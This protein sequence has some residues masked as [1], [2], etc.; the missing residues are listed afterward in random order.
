MKRGFTLLELLVVVGIISILAAL[1]TVSFA[2]VQTRSRDSRRREDMKSVQDSLE[3]YYA[4]NSFVYPSDS[5]TCKA[6]ISSY[7]KQ[8]LPVDPKT[9]SDY[10][11]TCTTTSYC[12]CATL[13]AGNGNSTV[14]DCTGWADG[15]YYCV[16]SLQ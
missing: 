3:Q 1:L 7:I 2:A 6:A 4:N 11:I 8:S 14:T 12:I 10:D 9:G 13:E 16:G 5:G 15:N